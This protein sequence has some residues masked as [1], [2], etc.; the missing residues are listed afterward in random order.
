M[1]MNNPGTMPEGSKKGEYDIEPFDS[2]EM[3]APP[4]GEYTEPVLVPLEETEL[5]DELP[6]KKYIPHVADADSRPSKTGV[7]VPVTNPLKIAIDNGDV[8][9]DGVTSPE[10]DEEDYDEYDE[11]SYEDDYGNGA[12]GYGGNGYEP[13]YGYD[14]DPYYPG[15]PQSRPQKLFLSRFSKGESSFVFRL[16]LVNIITYTIWSI[17]YFVCLG[18]REAAMDNAIQQMLAMGQ[19][20]FTVEVSS[21]LFTLLKIMLFVLPVLLIVWTV[22]ILV[23]NN[24]KKELCDRRIILVSYFVTLFVGLLAVIDVFA[25]RIM[26]E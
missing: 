18:Y 7:F 11:G 19:T 12:P 15:V 26:F 20:M 8:R 1:D 16:S 21:P 24:K 23:A 25:L 17:L 10:N 5:V 14:D 13:D 9:I 2:G 3:N 6:E 4:R 22:G